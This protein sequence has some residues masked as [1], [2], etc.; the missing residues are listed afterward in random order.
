M[1]NSAILFV[2][3]AAWVAQACSESSGKSKK[4]VVGEKIPVQVMKLEKKNVSIP[5]HASGQFTTDD[6]TNLSF[7]T[8][9]V[10]EKIFVREGDRVKAGQLLATLDLTEIE[11][12]VSQARLGYEKA[13]RDYERVTNLYRDSVA[14][15]EQFQNAKTGLDVA[16]RQYEA[17]KFNRTYSEIRAVSGGFV[18]K[19]QANAG[20]V[21]S[22][23]ST[24]ITTN[25]AGSGKWFLKVGVS[26]RDWARINVNDEAI[27]FTDAT[28]GQSLSGLVS[29]KSE[30]TDA[31]TGSFS[32][33]I[34]LKGKLPATIASGMFGKAEIR[35]ASVQHSWAIP[36]DALLDGD[37]NSGYVF[38]TDNMKTARKAEVKISTLDDNTILVTAGLEN[39]EAL[40]VSGSAYLRDQSP[41]QIIETK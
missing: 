30:G 39:A 41:I 36:Y 8:G 13:T 28:P 7:K 10:I 2:I 5:I 25:G 22:P 38:V 18:L 27:V 3:L 15:L 12:Q 4:I 33:E 32:I 9:G 31:Y 37:G 29:K 34:T 23:G 6:E 21:I 16:T 24:V 14:T 26:D 17:A 40:I 1:K 19:K 11:A 35:P 20:Q